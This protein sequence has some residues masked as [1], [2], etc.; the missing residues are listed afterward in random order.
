MMMWWNITKHKV[1]AGNMATVKDDEIIVRP[2]SLEYIEE[3]AFE[4]AISYL[5]KK[6]WIT[7]QR[8]AL[9]S[10]AENNSQKYFLSDF[11]DAFRQQVDKKFLRPKM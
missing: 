2:M 9:D 10:G 1:I 6:K 5:L 8:T 4:K 11:V 3:E 7:A